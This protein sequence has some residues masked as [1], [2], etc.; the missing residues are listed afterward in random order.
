VLKSRRGFFRR[1][2]LI[3]GGTLVVGASP[4]PLLAQAGGNN[5]LQDCSPIPP[6]PAT[7]VPFVPDTSISVRTRYSAFNMPAARVTQLR[8]AYKL[9]RDLT[10]NSPDDPRGWLRQANV[11]CWYCGGE[12]GDGVNAGPEVHGSWTFLP[13][14]RMFLYVHERILGELVG[15]NTLTLPFWDWDTTVHDRLPP[16]FA[17]PMANGAPNPLFD[18][19]RGAGPGDIIPPSIVGPLAI[20]Q[21]LAPLSF[22]VPGGF[23]GT[24]NGPTSSAGTLEDNPHGPVHIWTGDPSLQ[25]ANAD[26]GILATAAR[27]P[28]FFAHHANIDRL[29]DVWLNQGQ[30]RT[31]PTSSS[32]CVESFNFYNQNASPTWMSMSFSD[33]IDHVNSL[34]YTYD[35]T[36][37]PVVQP[38]PPI[39]MAVQAGGG[40]AFDLSPQSRDSIKVPAPAQPAAQ[41]VAPGAPKP[42]YV[43]H[44]EG[45]DIPPDKHAIIRVFVEKPDADASTGI[46]SPNFV[47][48]FS[49]VASGKSM[50]AGAHAGTR[51]THKHIHNKALVLTDQQ[52]AMLKSKS[53]LEVKLVS[54]GSSVKS[55]PYKRV[56]ITIR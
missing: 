47:G 44:I 1:S 28:I 32:W 51:A 30:G 25:S 17:D 49:I 19:N 52:V 9:M 24:P 5:P 31:N 2:G 38:C 36:P 48:Q 50:A 18:A 45:I 27:D 56:Y 40:S 20:Q 55:L 54:A 53:N 21:M 39:A 11:H 3:V 13:W 35:G 8:Q 46:D 4:S 16:I 34:R 12:N 22:D 14:H 43:L 6:P 26:M 37:A 41:A 23:G 29:W 7:A 42:V 33:T 10:Q 15:D